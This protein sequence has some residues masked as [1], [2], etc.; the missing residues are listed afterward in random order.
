[1][2]QI[3]ERNEFVDNRLDFEECSCINTSKYMYD[4]EGNLF[5]SHITDFLRNYNHFPMKVVHTLVKDMSDSDYDNKAHKFKIESIHSIEEL[6]HI[7]DEVG[8]KL[9]N[10][11]FFITDS[12]NPITFTTY[13][14]NLEKKKITAQK[15]LFELG[16]NETL[17]E[18]IN[19]GYEF[20]L[21]TNSDK[22]S[23]K[24]HVQ[25]LLLT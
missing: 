8:W 23:T 10:G 4:I 1:M 14:F 17:I 5:I 6:N 13:E 9:I 25:K 2:I 7:L 3:S 20:L 12:I 22:L 19:H 15:P 21:A 18:A 24:E 16:N 11:K